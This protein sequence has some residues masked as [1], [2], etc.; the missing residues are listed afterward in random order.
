MKI[1]SKIVE[2]SRLK[3]R[4]PN[5]KMKGW[6]VISILYVIFDADCPKTFQLTDSRNAV[7]Y[8][9]ASKAMQTAYHFRFE[10]MFAG[11]NLVIIYCLL[12]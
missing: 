6:I 8:F 9:I 2:F 7:A 11:M 4:I 12:N 3:G 5:P 1:S 10:C